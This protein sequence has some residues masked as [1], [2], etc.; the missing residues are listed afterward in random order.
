MGMAWTSEPRK[1][2]TGRQAMKTADLKGMTVAELRSEWI[3][4]GGAAAYW[5]SNIVTASQGIACLWYHFEY[6]GYR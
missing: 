2:L 1:T 6:R 3:K 5:D 4:L